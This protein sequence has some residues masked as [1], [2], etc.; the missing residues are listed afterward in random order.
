MN[1]TYCRN[2]FV[3]GH[4][5]AQPVRHSHIVIQFKTQNFKMY[6]N[7]NP[8]MCKISQPRHSRSFSLVMPIFGGMFRASF[9][10]I[11]YVG[12]STCIALLDGPLSGNRVNSTG[13]LGGE[14]AGQRQL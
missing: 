4:K 1:V 10:H 2:R 5:A 3:K 6:A 12:S 13:W 11:Q 14:C 8:E 7:I 9:S